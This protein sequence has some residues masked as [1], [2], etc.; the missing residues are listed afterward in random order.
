MP[1]QAPNYWTFVNS[2]NNAVVG[3]LPPD[4]ALYLKIGAI[5]GAFSIGNNYRF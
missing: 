2:H 1:N 5:L 4:V 3:V